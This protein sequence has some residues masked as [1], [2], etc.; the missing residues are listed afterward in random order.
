MRQKL[1]EALTP[2]GER[3]VITGEGADSQSGL[4]RLRTL[5]RGGP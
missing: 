3:A 2:L 4:D 5:T 1:T